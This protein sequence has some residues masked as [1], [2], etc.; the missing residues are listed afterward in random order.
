MKR[1]WNPKIF[2]RIKVILICIFLTNVYMSWST[3][4]LAE[5]VKSCI[6]P[7]YIGQNYLWS[8]LGFMIGV[9]I[10]FGYDCWTLEE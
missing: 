3:N 5:G 6:N 1:G 4:C 10:M 7:E 2:L 8:A 9:V